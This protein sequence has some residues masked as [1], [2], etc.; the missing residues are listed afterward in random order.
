MNINDDPDDFDTMLKEFVDE[1]E[2]I[3]SQMMSDQL[4][5]TS[6][7][8]SAVGDFQELLVASTGKMEKILGK[9][10]KLPGGILDTILPVRDKTFFR[11]YATS[12]GCL[13]VLAVLAQRWDDMEF[14]P[15]QLRDL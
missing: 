14:L 11:E 5:T 10:R 3:S 7:A 2:T 9:K 1:W 8:M 4:P 12:I 15:P 13:Y 6:F